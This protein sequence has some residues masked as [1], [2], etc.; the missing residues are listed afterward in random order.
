MTVGVPVHVP[1]LTDSSCPSSAVPVTA[2]SAVLA[3]GAAT[4]VAVCADVA[5][6]DPALFVAPTAT[7]IV[8]PTCDGV[9]PN[10]V[11]VAPAML[12]QLVP[13]VLHVSHCG[14]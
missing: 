6:P 3:G 10:V 7:R 12:E 4:T 8:V 9:S 1:L 2:G 5:E 14:P 13:D 11:P